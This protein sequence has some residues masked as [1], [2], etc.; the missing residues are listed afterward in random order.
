MPRH[1][2]IHSVLNLNAFKTKPLTCFN[3]RLILKYDTIL[4]ECMGVAGS[5]DLHLWVL[6]IKMGQNI[7]DPTTIQASPPCLLHA[8]TIATLN[9]YGCRPLEKL[10]PLYFVTSVQ[11]LIHGEIRLWMTTNSLPQHFSLSLWWVMLFVS[12]YFKFS[13]H[14]WN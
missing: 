8:C 6:L 11:Q 3:L 12:L 10:M 14:Q 5:V 7:L 1:A 2:L 9:S 13:G 4:L